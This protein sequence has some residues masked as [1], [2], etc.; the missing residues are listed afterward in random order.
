MFVV[1]LPKWSMW[2]TRPRSATDETGATSSRIGSSIG[3]P[4]FDSVSPQASMPA[5][6]AKT[7]R[8]WNVLLGNCSGRQVISS[9]RDLRAAAAVHA[10]RP[11]DQAVVGADD[12]L[13]LDL[14]DQHAPVGADAGVDDGE[15]RGAGREAVDGALQRDRAAQHVLRRDLVRDVDQP[16]RGA[17]PH[18]N[19]L[20]RGDVAIA[21]A[22]V[23]GKG[24]QRPVLGAKIALARGGRRPRARSRS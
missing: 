4:S 17:V 24:Y 19:G 3:R 1:A 22:E 20:H 9:P 7:S 10:P 15:V 12:A 18:Q 11:G 23:A 13:L 21:E 8:P 2:I 5:T 16:R 14:D 6:G